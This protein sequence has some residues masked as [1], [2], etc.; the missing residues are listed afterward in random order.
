MQPIIAATLVFL[1]A[2]LVLQG[3]GDGDSPPPPPQ[4]DTAPPIMACPTPRG[5]IPSGTSPRKWPPKDE[6]SR[7]TGNTGK[8]KVLMVRHAESMANLRDVSFV[9]SC[10][11]S[12]GFA[13][14][15]HSFDVRDSPL[16]DNGIQ[17]A[18]QQG[19]S[20]TLAS[21]DTPDVVLVSPM[22]RTIQTAM[23][24]IPK[25]W[26]QKYSAESP[27][28]RIYFMPLLTE[29]AAPE[30]STRQGGV[31]AQQTYQNWGHTPSTWFNASCPAE[32]AGAPLEYNDTRAVCTGYGGVKSWIE[33]YVNSTSSDGYE[34]FY[35]K[36]FFEF[37]SRKEASLWS[38]SGQQ[39]VENA[40]SLRKLLNAELSNSK[41]MI[42]THHQFLRALISWPENLPVD[43][44]F[45][46]HAPP[47]FLC[48]DTSDSI[49]IQ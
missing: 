41:V 24:V 47:S 26:L 2:G 45:A 32:Q 12:K 39:C 36:A 22:L 38:P 46:G 21:L 44:P 9:K 10:T 3:C 20:K 16:S 40:V 37:W 33:Q 1:L 29:C 14:C 11:T 15:N 7:V 35:N 19:Q 6:A 27:L 25:A 48:M 49:I 13:G 31:W 5:A 4:R 23:H 43:D 17:T 8:Y 34:G 28:P 30:T 18:R 42:V